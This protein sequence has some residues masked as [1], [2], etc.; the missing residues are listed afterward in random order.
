MYL[1]VDFD[2]CEERGCT[3]GEQLLCPETPCA[4]NG[5]SP[6]TSGSIFAFVYSDGSR[7]SSMRGEHVILTDIS[8]LLIELTTGTSFREVK[9]LCNEMVNVCAMITDLD[10]IKYGTN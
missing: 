6:K 10:I 8:T 1:M 5:A 3:A 2:R 4:N 7:V 9:V